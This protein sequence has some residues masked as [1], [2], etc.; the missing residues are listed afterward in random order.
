M[1][2][3]VIHSVQSPFL[4]PEECSG[5]LST[6]MDN[7]GCSKMPVCKLSGKYFKLVVQLSHRLPIMG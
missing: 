3:D 4:K 7:K 5:E 1:V 6:F 2:F